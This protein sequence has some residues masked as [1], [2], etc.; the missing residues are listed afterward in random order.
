MKLIE[1]IVY[2][3][4]LILISAGIAQSYFV[5]HPIQEASIRYR[6]QYTA[7][8]YVS[9][10]FRNKTGGGHLISETERG[11][12]KNKVNSLFGVSDTAIH[13]TKA[14]NKDNS[15]IFS[16]IFI[17]QGKQYEIL[18]VYEGVL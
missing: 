8:K 13:I 14:V 17:L 16:C 5:L 6:E 9:E 11:E 10:D 3:V 1:V 12:W 2:I 7:L 15:Y 18:S 4:L